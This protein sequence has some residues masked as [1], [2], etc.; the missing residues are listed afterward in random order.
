MIESGRVF[1][2][3]GQKYEVEKY[4]HYEEKYICKNLSS[5]NF[6]MVKFTEKQIL[7]GK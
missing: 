6:E 3:E 4:D 1:N 2:H 7:G 5:H